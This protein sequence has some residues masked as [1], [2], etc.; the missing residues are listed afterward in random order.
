MVYKWSYLTTYSSR[1]ENTEIQ[2]QT[3]YLDS[4]VLGTN[5]QNKGSADILFLTIKY[6]NPLTDTKEKNKIK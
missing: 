5:P 2:Q 3:I 1:L 4:G 6:N